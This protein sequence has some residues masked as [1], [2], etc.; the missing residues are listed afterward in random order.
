[1]G[2]VHIPTQ[3]TRQF[4]MSSPHAE[5]ILIEIKMKN[6]NHLKKKN[7]KIDVSHYTTILDN[8][9]PTQF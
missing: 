5:Y 1:M 7:P 4:S 3:T 6:S 9:T 2:K 8:T